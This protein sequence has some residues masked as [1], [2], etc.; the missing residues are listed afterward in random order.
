MAQCSERQHLATTVA[1]PTKTVLWNTQYIQ[2][3]TVLAASYCGTVMHS[4]VEHTTHTVKHT[5]HNGTHVEASYCGGIVLW[6]RDAV[7]Q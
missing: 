5:A 2:C 6:L 4:A 7:A 3:C 1:H